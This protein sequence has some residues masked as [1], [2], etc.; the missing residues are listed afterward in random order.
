MDNQ[1]NPNNYNPY[2]YGVNQQ[3]GGPYYPRRPYDPYSEPMA[4]KDWIFTF[5]LLMIPFANIIL[6][7]VWAFGNNVN[8]SKKT[9]FQAYLIFMLVGVIIA[10]VIT[11]LFIS[12]F[13]TLGYQLSE[14][15][16]Y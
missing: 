8:R 7:F 1:Y 15:T 10:A 13:A 11:I 9:F 14:F 3:Q 12:L 4:L 2:N 16:Y 6:P 5:L